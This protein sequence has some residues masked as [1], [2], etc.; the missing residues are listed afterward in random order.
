MC[1]AALFQL[2]IMPLR[3]L[4]MIASSDDSTIA[5]RSQASWSIHPATTGLPRSGS[6][7]EPAAAICSCGAECLATPAS[8]DSISRQQRRQP[9][10][11]LTQLLRGISNISANGYKEAQP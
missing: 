10:T 8:R 3:S 7:D 1:S 4:L 6:G 9:T 2:V 11:V 5:E